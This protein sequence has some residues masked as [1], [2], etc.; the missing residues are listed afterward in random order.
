MQVIKFIVCGYSYF[1]FPS[2][3][4]NQTPSNAEQEQLQEQA[5][6]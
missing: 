1:Y 2:R 6:L 4:S 3:A 5:K